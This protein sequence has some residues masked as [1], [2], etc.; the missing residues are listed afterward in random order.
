MPRLQSHCFQHIDISHC[1]DAI[2]P[3]V[4]DTFV[5]P[6]DLET[7]RALEEEWAKEL[8]LDLE[9]ELGPF[10][11]D[12]VEVHVPPQETLELCL[13]G[14]DLFNTGDD[15]YMNDAKTEYPR[16]MIDHAAG[17]ILKSFGIIPQRMTLRNLTKQYHPHWYVK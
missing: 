1:W 8:K 12:T 14:L 3:K 11:P 2:L 16:V 5:T 9:L 10:S 13:R 6:S 7:R 4:S 17:S 15:I